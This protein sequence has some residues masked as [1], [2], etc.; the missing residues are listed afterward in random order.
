MI[1]D[2]SK[3]KVKI[4]DISKKIKKINPKDLE[5]ALGAELIERRH[6]VRRMFKCITRFL[7]KGE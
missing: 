2:T 4:K 1:K 3:I 7:K 5:Q 6:Y